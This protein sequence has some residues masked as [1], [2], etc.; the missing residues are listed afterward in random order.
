MH[1]SARPLGAKVLWVPSLLQQNK[2]ALE[3]QNCPNRTDFHIWTSGGRRGALGMR[4]T[5][6]TYMVL[7]RFMPVALVG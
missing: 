6:G 1:A 4:H 7:V 5:L 2:E 3:R